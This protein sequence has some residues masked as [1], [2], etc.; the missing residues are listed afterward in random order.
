MG[1]AEKHL[2][3]HAQQMACHMRD[4]AADNES[5]M[6]LTSKF[7]DDVDKHSPS[8]RWRLLLLCSLAAELPSSQPLVE[9]AI[10]SV[11]LHQALR[12]VPDGEYMP[13]LLSMRSQVGKGAPGSFL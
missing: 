3:Y 11:H 5:W 9:K 10:A 4:S 8:N 7:M 6:D 12:K 2:C 13:A 1:Q